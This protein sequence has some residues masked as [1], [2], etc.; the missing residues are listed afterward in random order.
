MGDGEF[1]L[2]AYLN[3][4]KCVSNPLA[5][6]LHLKLSSGGLREVGSWDGFRPRNRISPRPIPSV[7]YFWRKYWGN[8]SAVFG[9]IQDIPFSYSPY[10][11]KGSIKGN[12]ISL[13]F[14]IILFPL[15]FTQVIISWQISSRMITIGNKIPQLKS[16]LI[17]A[18]NNNDKL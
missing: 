4:F 6:R 16:N 2:R 18:G 9:L 11:L 13:L 15:S 17:P 10:K 7:L 8:Q 14:F 12:I 1:G 3:G 5:K